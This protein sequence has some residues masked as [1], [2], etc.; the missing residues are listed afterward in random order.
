MTTPASSPPPPSPEIACNWCGSTSGLHDP[1]CKLVQL[2]A[3]ATPP[4]PAP[5]EELDR[6]VVALLDAKRWLLES[7]GYT[8]DHKEFCRERFR[9]ARS[10]LESIYTRQREEIERLRGGK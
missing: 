1:K 4:S 3:P 9:T 8:E 10:A 5:T 2:G 7:E 6:I